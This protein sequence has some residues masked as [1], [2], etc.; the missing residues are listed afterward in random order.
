MSNRKRTNLRANL[1]GID[2]RLI[3]QSFVILFGFIAIIINSIFEDMGFNFP[4]Y[5][6]VISLILIILMILEE[7]WHQFKNH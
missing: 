1:H 3:W 6:L 2:W 7:A 4:F 5:I